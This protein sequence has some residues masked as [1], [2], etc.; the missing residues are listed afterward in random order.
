MEIRQE[1]RCPLRIVSRL[2]P[3][4]FSQHQVGRDH[5]AHENKRGRG[6]DPAAAAGTE[7]QQRRRASRHPFAEKDPGDD[8]PGYDEEHVDADVT[9][10]E[11]VDTHMKED[12]QE[13]CDHAQALDVRSEYPFL[14][15]GPGLVS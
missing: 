4:C 3:C 8:V 1:E 11:V 15:C 9:P 10:G 7:A 13:D 6:E 5:G 14:G 2:R 12:H